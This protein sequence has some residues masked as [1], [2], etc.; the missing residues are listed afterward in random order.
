M[1][2]ALFAPERTTMIVFRRP[3]PSEVRHDQQF[4]LLVSS[5]NTVEE[6]LQASG[7]CVCS[8][9]QALAEL[10]RHLLP[11]EKRLRPEAVLELFLQLN[12]FPAGRL[13]VFSDDQPQP[14]SIVLSAEQPAE[15]V[16][17]YYGWVG[18]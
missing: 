17:L 11:E 2:T 16:R 14:E 10:R 7:Q 8:D 9:R 5:G 1:F 6:C 13:L 3:P 18:K 15:S 12:R 4:A